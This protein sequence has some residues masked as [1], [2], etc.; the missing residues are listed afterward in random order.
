MNA[1]AQ[2][3]TQSNDQS[4]HDPIAL[5]RVLGRF[6]TG[7]AVV[8][9]RTDDSV[10]I[11]LTINSF[12]SVSLNP[13]LVSWCLRRDAA[14]FPIF[15]GTRHWA[16]SVLGSTQVHLARQFCGPLAERFQDVAYHDGVGGVP[17]LEGAIAR[18]ECLAFSG[19]DGGDHH[20]FL[21]QVQDY[22][23]GE[24]SPLVFHGGSF[25]DWLPHD[26]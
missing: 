9:T 19:I 5:R 13:P 12:A 8:T 14:S 17:L 6:A 2:P 1:L 16:I 26:L 21:G 24:G 15:A 10:P 23:T 25:G 18:L 20:I 22:A 7:V 3:V 4:V 11:G